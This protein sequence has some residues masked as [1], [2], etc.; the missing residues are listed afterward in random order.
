[1][2]NASH[3]PNLSSFLQEH[4]LS[5][6]LESIAEAV[7]I[8]DDKNVI[9]YVNKAFT[10][11]YGYT[12][13]E[14]IGQPVNFLRRDPFE[15]TVDFILD[16][17]KEGGWKGEIINVRKN[18]EE[19]PVFLST[20]I[21][22]D[23]DGEY[24]GLIGVATDI[25][26]RKKADEAYRVLVDHSIQGLLLLT[27]NNILFSN[28]RAAEILGSDEETLRQWN[29]DEFILLFHP[30][31]RKAVQEMF[32]R[33][34]QPAETTLN[35][36]FRIITAEGEQK[37]IQLSSSRI[38]FMKRHALQLAF[39]DITNRKFAEV[40]FNRI[41][42]Q[43]EKQNLVFEELLRSDFTDYK[44]SL[45]RVMVA[46]AN[47]MDCELASIWLY[48]EDET[49]LECIDQ[50]NAKSDRHDSGII[51]ESSSNPEYFKALNSERI[52]S[53]PD[54]YEDKRT[55]GFSE[56]FKEAGIISLLDVRIGYG[57]GFS[58]VICFEECRSKRFWQEDE[59][60]FA[61]RVVDVVSFLLESN[62]RNNTEIALRESEKKLLEL[63]DTKDRFFSIIAHD[64]KNPFNA[65]IG[66]TELLHHDYD[67]YSDKEK[68][69][70][71]RNIH[72]SA[73]NTFK[74]LEN[75]L[76]WAVVQTGEAKVRPES[77]D[78]F[79][80][81]SDTVRLLK[82]QADIK[83]VQIIFDIKNGTEAWVDGEMIKTVLRNLLSN[84]IHYSNPGGKITI[85]ID[86]VN[87]HGKKYV[88][89][90][91]ADQG[92][93]I[94]KENLKRLFK[95]GEKFHTDGTS[96]EK[97]TG[98]GLIL[99]HEFITVNQGEIW[100]ESEEGKGSEFCFILPVSPYV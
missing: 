54:V 72:D 92:V 17:T 25:S 64:L 41:H 35:G 10:K 65:I 5:M 57:S 84:A 20:S 58:G 68:K 100:A 47:T 3:T 26:E 36:E 28:V 56:Y 88:S 14:L 31:E 12:R 2:E 32:Q 45:S 8:T 90:I 11:I 87:K 13:E 39:I 99:C 98:L 95:V 44:R 79:T 27:E 63:V 22:R 21:I 50:Y 70:I 61:V 46:A 71:L 30:L 91:I 19:F 62:K 75:L 42:H 55:I 43:F 73:H 1:M 34:S 81:V 6:A 86:T 18:G 29:K 9:L 37:W 67:R 93:G 40:G 78:I 4:F 94:T 82:P 97:G 49:A 15:E 89:V 83:K 38:S 24:L 53:V 60:A 77:I 80:L 52:I 96:G 48:N 74:L 85:T 66:F 59:I 23:A 51:L 7:S 76:E 69:V 16:K 33:S